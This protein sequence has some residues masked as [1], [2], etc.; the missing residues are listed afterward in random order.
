MYTDLIAEYLEAFSNLYGIIPMWKA[1]SIIDKQNPELKLTKEQ[2]AENVS[3]IDLTDKFFD[4]LAEEELYN[5][6]SDD[7]DFFKKMLIAEY[8]LCD[9]D[10]DDYECLAEEQQYR[11]YYIPEK[12]E[13]LKYRDELYFEKTDYARNFED[14]LRDE[15]KMTNSD[16]VI[17]DFQITMRIDTVDMDE[18]IFML[19]TG[20]PK[21]K[22][23]KTKKQADK[24]VQLVVD[25]NNHTR[26]HTLRGN[27]PCELGT[28]YD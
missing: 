15:L 26:M 21:F 13:L 6:P 5:K 25:L 9:D 2:F 8:L 23:F 18:A 20:R 14:F 24:F 11:P 10:P 27:T 7:I 16:E 3:H 19:R 28:I 12:E 22:Q 1:Y 4:I 17:E